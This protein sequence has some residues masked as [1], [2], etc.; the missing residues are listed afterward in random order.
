MMILRSCTR[1]R[2]IATHDE[3]LEQLDVRVHVNGI[4]GKSSVTRL[5]AGV[6]R[7]GG[8]V[9]VAKTTG[10]AARVIDRHGR[11]TPI[12]RRGAAT[13]NEQVEVVGRHVTDDVEALVIECMAVRPL[14]QEFSQERMVRS[15][16]TRR[17]A[18]RSRR[19]PTRCRSRSPTVGSS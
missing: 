2:S 18:R 10:S 19:S 15:D 4:R 16:I 17:W 3:R 8:F 1:Q 13:I 6:L 5:V 9:T 14:Y 12:H 7:E 11:E